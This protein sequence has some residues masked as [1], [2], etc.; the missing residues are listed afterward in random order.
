ME[1]VF[2]GTGAGVPTTA[3]NVTAIAIA[4]WPE[5]GAVW[6]FD[7]GEGTQHQLL[8]A[9]AAAGPRVRARQVERVF[10][11]HMHGDHLFG[12]PGLLGTRSFQAADTPLT[13]YGPPGTR[14]Y[15]ETSLEVSQTHLTYPLGIVEIESPGIVHADERFQVHADWLEHTIPTLGY[16][17]VERDRPGRLLTDRLATLGV[18]PGPLYG[19]L[20]QG[21]SIPLP[22]GST[23]HPDEVL[24]PPVPG[25]VVAILGDTRPCQAAVELASGAD[26]LVHEATFAAD[27]SA[28]APAYGHSTAADAAR[29][30]HDAG[31]KALILTHISAR[32][33]GDGA[34]RLL[35][36]A[37][38]IFPN[39]RLASDLW[40]YPVP[41]SRA[42]RAT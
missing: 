6:L 38:A 17:V 40:S 9:P 37:R 2:L 7:C 36:E 24:A 4:L 20:K 12:L 14:R 19:R 13:V 35:A 18:P 42:G 31:A 39:T 28:L 16:R 5:R 3:R 26:V 41:A 32:Y 33:S 10:L 27:R 22:D 25:R 15:L 29:T 11:T 8:R 34:D 23:L 21:Q 1:L 30:A